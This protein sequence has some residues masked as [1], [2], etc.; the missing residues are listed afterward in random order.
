MFVLYL[1]HYLQRLFEYLK[2]KDLP[3]FSRG[4]AQQLSQAFIWAG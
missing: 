1:F 2:L 3:K 4:L